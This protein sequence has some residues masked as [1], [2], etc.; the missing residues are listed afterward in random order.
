M[1]D[2]QNNDDQQII[3]YNTPDG[4]ASVA[5]L[6]KDGNIW[7][8][9]YQMAELF[10]TSKQIISY[11]AGNILKDKELKGNSV[12]KEYLTTAPDGKNYKVNFY[13]LEMILA[14]GFRVKGKRGTQFRQWANKNLREYMIK[15][16]VIDDDRLKKTE[17]LLQ[18]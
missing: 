1:S 17:S 6:A 7:M 11:H 15:G 8:N 9:Q 2:D 12:V 4:K 3:I 16:F 14:I 18:N 5:L 10:A 13:S